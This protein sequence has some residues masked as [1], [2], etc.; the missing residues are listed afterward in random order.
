MYM[1]VGS[2][3]APLLFYRTAESRSVVG[4]WQATRRTDPCP[5]SCSSG[6]CLVNFM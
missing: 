3:N 4:Y 6:R 1:Y 2:L 5:W